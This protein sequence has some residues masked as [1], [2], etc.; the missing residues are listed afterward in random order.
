MYNI[1]QKPT[2]KLKTG[3]YAQAWSEENKSYLTIGNIAELGKIIGEAF[4]CC[5]HRQG[6]NIHFPKMCLKT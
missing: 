5:V 1:D 3:K 6:A 4:F 2:I